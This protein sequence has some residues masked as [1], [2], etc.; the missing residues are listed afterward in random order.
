MDVGYEKRVVV[1][2]SEADA[3]RLLGELVKQSADA[4]PACAELAQDL[5]DL[6]G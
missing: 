3:L 5:D 1:K 4:F 2:L 6:L